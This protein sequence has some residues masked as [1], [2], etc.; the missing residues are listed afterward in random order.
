LFCIRPAFG[1]R[2]I[3]GIG[4]MNTQKVLLD[5]EVGKQQMLNPRQSTLR[6]STNKTNA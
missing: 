5:G 6:K 2:V 3:G 4:Q 1:T